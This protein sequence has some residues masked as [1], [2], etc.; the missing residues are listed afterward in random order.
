MNSGD[1]KSFVN[2]LVEH[3]P[4]IYA[5]IRS[6]IA[7]RSAAD[8]VYQNTCAVLWEKF[9]QWEQ[10]TSFIHWALEVARYETLSF[11]RD[12]ARDRL[13]L[14]PEVVELIEAEAATECESLSELR[15]ALEHCLDQLS[16]ASRHMLMQRYEPGASV[17]QLAEQEGCPV[18]TLYT[19]LKRVRVKLYR[20]IQAN[21]HS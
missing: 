12:Q 4:R 19:R 13:T 10:G 14:D 6:V 5:F 3:Q 9:G 7:D 16:A 8:D 2:L 17:I 18:A 21:L 20:C 1:Q 11:R 15:S